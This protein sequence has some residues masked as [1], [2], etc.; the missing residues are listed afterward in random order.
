MMGPTE[1]AKP[2][3]T[4]VLSHS[5]VSPALEII[6]LSKTFAG[7]KALEAVDLTLL[8]GEVHALLGANGSGKSTLIK[9]LSGFHAPDPG[10]QFLLNGEPFKPSADRKMRSSLRFVH[11]DQGL[12]LELSAID[13]IALHGEF[14]RT[15]LGTID[16]DS[17]LARAQRALAYFSGL[18]GFNVDRPVREATPVQRTIIAIASALAGWEGEGGV[19]VLDE[20]TASLPPHEV[21]ILLDVVRDLRSRGTAILYV[22][23][24]LDEIIRLADRVTVLRG[25]NMVHSSPLGSLGVA[26]LGALINGSAVEE[27][28]PPSP[29]RDD[30]S[31]DIVLEVRGLDGHE[32]KNLDL[33]VRR[34]ET[35]GLF[36][37]PGSGASAVPYALAGAT[38]KVR[39]EVRYCGG[40]WRP[41]SQARNLNIPIVPA[42]RFREAI[43]AEQSVRENTT[44]SALRQV[45][46]LGFIKPAG[47]KAMARDWIEKLKV[48]TSSPEANITSLSGGNQQKAILARCL[49]RNPEVVL[50]CEPTAG[51]DIGARGTIHREIVSRAD[52]GCAFI[53]W[54]TDTT[55]LVATCSRVLILKDGQVAASL[56]GNEI[57]DRA[58]VNALDRTEADS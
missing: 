40:Q 9:T 21:D 10:P 26:D 38:A 17:Q 34:G 52:D 33:Y 53:V 2:Y 25:G 13:N 11:Q 28:V 54:S 42:D 24:R 30:E 1:G 6:G 50:L 36:G 31:H 20:P 58:L 46:P 14:V 47:E 49:A 18:Q 12:F 27:S 43:F 29:V 37:L 55:D 4:A 56:V 8:A 22:S 23:H 39:G 15:R 45:A 16:W 41:L 57:T 35:L 7:T 19:L 48:K 5:G 51:V 44:V 32:L 3:M